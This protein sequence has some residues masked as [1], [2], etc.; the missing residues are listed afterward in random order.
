MTLENSQRGF[1]TAVEKS[2]AGVALTPFCP[3]KRFCIHRAIEGFYDASFSMLD[4]SPHIH[5]QSIQD[6][7]AF[8]YHH[9]NH[10]CVFLRPPIACMIFRALQDF[11]NHSSSLLGCLRRFFLVHLLRE[12]PP[13]GCSGMDFD[14]SQPVGHID[15]VSLQAPTE[16]G[17]SPMR[18]ARRV[19]AAA[20]S[21]LFS[22]AENM[23]L[24]GILLPVQT[25]CQMDELHEIVA[26]LYKSCRHR[27]NRALLEHTLGVTC[28]WLVVPGGE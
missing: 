17:V 2:S 27:E 23:N 19:V 25:H 15:A 28:K 14:P 10:M 20:Y 18:H 1:Q 5:N 9:S 24:F 3:S 8:C 13:K 7:V 4:F 12:T 22:K 6:V 16:E 21:A 11:S 26:R